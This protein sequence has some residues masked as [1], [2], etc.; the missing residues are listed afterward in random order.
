MTEALNIDVVLD[1]PV[2][3][4]RQIVDQIRTFCV[5]GRLDPGQ[6]LPS[7]RALA[8]N[9]G[10]HFNTVAEAYRSLADEGWLEVRQGRSVRVRPRPATEAPT[11]VLLDQQGA[12]LRHLIAELRG[13]GITPQW[14]RLQME[15]GLRNSLQ[16]EAQ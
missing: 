16:G 14:I 9:L 5:G 2:P 4:Y 12:R 3:A 13:L 11:R 15:E 7:V 10:V 8:R 6:E 1:G